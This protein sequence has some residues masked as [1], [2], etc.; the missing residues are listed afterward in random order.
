[1]PDVTFV[2]MS[3]THILPSADDRLHGVDPSEHFRRVVGWVR[4]MET[5]PA[6]FI[7]SGDLANGGEIDSYVRLKE[8]VDEMHDFGVPI[9]LGLGNHDERLPFRRVMLHDSETQDEADQ[10]YYSQ[11]INGLRILMLD[12][13]VPGKAWGQLG[14]RQLEWLDAELA[15]PAPAGEII[16]LHHPPAPRIVAKLEEQARAVGFR[17]QNALLDVLRGRHILGILSGHWHVATIGL[18]EGFLSAAAAATVFLG[19][20]SVSDGWRWYAGAG[21]NLCTVKDGTLYV[22]PL[23]VSESFK[24]AWTSRW[25]EMAARMQGTEMLV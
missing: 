22:N 3:D 13:K 10:H 9:L 24:D 11:T 25:S 14:S 17:D 23:I 18:W 6:F 15:T 2:H 20:P 19:D 1:M 4:A 12:S 5:K 16:V 8:L 7:I 21:F